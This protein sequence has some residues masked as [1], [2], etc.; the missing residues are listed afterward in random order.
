MEKAGN[1]LKGLFIGFHGGGEKY[2]LL[3][4]N[5]QNIVGSDL[6]HHVTLRDVK[7]NILLVE[8]AHPGWSQ[9]LLLKKKELLLKINALYP[10]LKIQDMKVRIVK[11]GTKT[12]KSK[13]DTILTSEAVRSGEEEDLEKVLARLDENELKKALKR[14]FAA[15]K[16]RFDEP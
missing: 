15:K 1:I 6:A 9:V 4:D 13:T 3:F 12:E 10:H 16:R 5:F 2:L 14:L 8:V 11:K 7:N